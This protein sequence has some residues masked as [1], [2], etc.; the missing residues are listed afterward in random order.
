M[1]MGMAEPGNSPGSWGGVDVDGDVVGL[2]LRY[3]SIGIELVVVDVHRARIDRGAYRQY[4]AEGVGVGLEFGRQEPAF[5][6]AHP[7]IEILSRLFADVQKKGLARGIES[8]RDD[9]EVGVIPVVQSQRIGIVLR[10]LQSIAAL[11]PPPRP[12]IAAE[13]FRGELVGLWILQILLGK[14]LPRVVA[15][16]SQ[17]RPSVDHGAAVQVD[18]GSGISF[19][20]PVVDFVDSQRDG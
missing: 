13:A 17:A 18:R 8:R 20:I 7:D 14:A 12:P 9:A 3:R 2:D 10:R 1:T 6:Q 15:T 5:R 16:P 11:L 19:L 4:Q